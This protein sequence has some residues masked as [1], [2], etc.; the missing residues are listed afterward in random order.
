M[1]DRWSSA[2]ITLTIAAGCGD[3]GPNSTTIV[4][5]PVWHLEVHNALAGADAAV[6]AIDY[7][8]AMDGELELGLSTADDFE[9]MQV[10]ESDGLRHVRLQ[11][12]YGG[13]PVVSSEVVV[14]ADDTTFIGLGGT[15]TRHLDGFDIVPT[16]TEGEAAAAALGDAGATA[17]TD[18]TSH[19]VILPG[20]PDGASLAWY[21]GFASGTSEW[22]YYVDAR[23]GA[24]LW[25]Y[26]GATTIE[27]GSGPGGN[28]KKLRTWDAELDVVL[29]DGMYRMKT[30]ALETQ[31]RRDDD[32]AYESVDLHFADPQANDAHGY[33][34]I[35]LQMMRGW[36]GRD[37]LD[38]NGFKIVSRVH[39]TS[40]CSGA[41]VNACW[42]GKKMYYGDGGSGFY[43]FSGSIDIVAHE[44][45]HGFTSFHSDLKYSKQ[46]GGL[47]ESFSDIAGTVAEFYDE[48]ESADFTIG[49]DIM[50]GAD[51]LRWMCEPGLDGWSASDVG[52]YT[53]DLDPHGASGVP[54]RAFCLAVARYKASSSGSSTLD[55]VRQVGHIWYTANAA[56]WT[57][58][59]TYQQACRGLIDA[60]YALGHSSEVAEALA[61]SW[62]D[63]G[64]MC[65]SAQLVCDHDDHCDAKDG[66]TCGSCPEDCGAC[67][68][69]CSKWKK[70]KCNIGIGDCS[71]CGQEPG[72]GDGICDGDETD[73][74]CG[75][76]CGCKALEC[77][78]LAPFGCWC[79]DLCEAAGD[80]CAD[81]GDV[82][83]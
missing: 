28:S 54:N 16:L 2:L 80:C 19:L 1:S 76:D 33:A 24:V 72:C 68:Q 52:D 15:V 62:R 26:D 27:Q 50:E 57:S 34:E 58:G 37:S 14:H 71:R 53:D 83:D 11:Q 78:A 40:K 25:K 55:A 70:A 41:P 8:K 66:E 17:P 22:N 21:V 38:D 35:T 64:V 36:M 12:T 9:V 82:C 59:T 74:S 4:T 31:D 77:E 3:S 23:S 67:S 61:D 18:Q 6:D 44:L 73:E 75:Q 79:D 65:E 69:S 10:T 48:G 5:A 30:D 32:D 81:R 63:V 42:S 49:E 60:S 20:D 29:D 56:Y 45:N 7:L 51:P 46:S 43:P 13:V 47:N 39:D